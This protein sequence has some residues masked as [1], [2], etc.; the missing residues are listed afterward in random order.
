MVVPLR[1]DW[2]DDRCP[3]ARSLDVV[4]DPWI[5]LIVRQALSG[6]RRF[7]QFRTELGI[8]DTVLSRRLQAL[9]DAGVLARSAYRD[10]RTRSEYVLTDAGA[11]LLPVLHALVLW[12][13]KHRPHADPD[14]SMQIVHAGCGA[15][16]STA[17]T[18]SACG[19]LLEPA[20][21]SWRRSWRPDDVPLS[22]IMPAVPTT[23]RA[24]APAP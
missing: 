23:D 11:D 15:V 18:C 16:T 6:A 20:A 22:G 9:V 4:G 2:S 10:G 12:G 17:D 8:A 19:D 3:I 13:E 5:L 21:V 1:S 7:E 14:V 24:T